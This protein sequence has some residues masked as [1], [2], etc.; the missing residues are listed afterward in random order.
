MKKENYLGW[1]NLVA[2]F[3][4]CVCV[5]VITVLETKIGTEGTHSATGVIVSRSV[6]LKEQEHTCVVF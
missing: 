3:C 4:V 6:Q 2:S 1:K 5:C